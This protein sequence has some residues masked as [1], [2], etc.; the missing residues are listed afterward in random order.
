MLGIVK[1][2][3]LKFKNTSGYILVVVL[4]LLATII[5]LTLGAGYEQ[6]SANN[7]WLVFLFPI[8][9][10][11][12][13]ITCILRE[14]KTNYQ[15]ILCLSI[16]LKDSWKGKIYSI[17]VLSFISNIIMMICTVVL[18]FIS[19]NMIISVGNGIVGYMLVFITTI[20]Q[21]PLI[22]TIAR[23][24]GYLPSI[25]GS[26]L[27]NL[28]CSTIITEKAYFFLNPFA[29]P[30]RVVYPFF[31]TR[32]NGLPIEEGSKFLNTGCVIPGLIVAVIV[33]IISMKISLNVYLKKGSTNEGIK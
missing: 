30:A 17:L 24:I 26:F 8:F 19:N 15:N 21:V 32:V 3:L 16:D 12:I 22:M 29:I 20:W 5:G 10:S 2:E 14:K 7:Y 13:S 1:S 23:F 4:P 25:I 18:G 28:L 27:I 11:I 31:K 6:N 33:T 9:I